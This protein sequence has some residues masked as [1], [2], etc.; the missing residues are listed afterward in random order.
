MGIFSKAQ[1]KEQ[2]VLVFDVGSSSVGG[3]LFWVQKSGVP[4]IIFSIREPVAL[5]ETVD[6]DR[7]LSLTAKSLET[8]AEKISAK[9]L[10]AP[11]EMF[12][13]LS[14]PWYASQTRT[15]SLQK[16]TPFVFNSKLA[17]SLIAKEINLFEEEHVKKYMDSGSKIVA[18]ELK[19]MK[20]MLN[21][22]PT[23]KPFNQ[24]AENLEMVMFIA[25]SAEQVLEK[26]KEAVGIHFNSEGIKF[27]SFAMAS[28]TV[29]RDVFANHQDFLLIDIGGEV[30][31]IS[32]VKKEILRES[33]SFP[34]GVNF[35]IRGVAREL[36]CTLEEA[37][38]FISLYK[39]GHAEEE[40]QQ[41]I[42]PIIST[43]RAEWLKNFQESL[44]NLSNDISIPSVIFVTVDQ[45]FADFFSETIKT[46]QLNQYTLTESKF[47]VI[48]VGTEALHGAAI[49][50]QNVVRDPFLIVE[51]IYIN[52]FLC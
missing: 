46:E 40:T 36:R 20:T 28:F 8:V 24:K 32:M 3:A 4:K 38:S 26:M 44:I 10:G 27:S 6:A 7:L 9:G 35:M 22:Y 21:G 13:V 51:S 43:L 48:F 29:V 52:R 5:E 11:K 14:S 12:C 39:D 31:D 45:D 2:L 16:N 1:K 47:Q 23:A 50:G 15:V 41:K 37:K 33:V 42:G 18:I 25:M 17:D 34:N 19:N 30:T 49:I